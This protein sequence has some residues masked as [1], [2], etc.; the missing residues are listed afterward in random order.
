MKHLLKESIYSNEVKE[1]IHQ[2]LLDM[3]VPS[4]QVEFS[5]EEAELAGAFS[6]DAL[7]VIDAL[8]SALD[9]YK[10]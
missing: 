8:E 6:D 9:V 5:P 1:V 3:M 7:S 10:E 4:Y 2:K